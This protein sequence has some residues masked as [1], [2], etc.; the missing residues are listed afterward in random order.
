[1]FLR[2]TY[3]YH[4]AKLSITDAISP[5][6][7]IPVST[8]YTPGQTWRFFL[9]G[10]FRACLLSALPIGVWFWNWLSNWNEPIAWHEFWLMFAACMGPPAGL[11]W[12]N[13]WHML[14]LPSV[15]IIPLEF[16]R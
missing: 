15:L 7:P 2:Y 14:K 16:E 11:Y 5:K 3:S 4:G 13:H 12:K 6:L 10:M 1:M 8:T 9:L